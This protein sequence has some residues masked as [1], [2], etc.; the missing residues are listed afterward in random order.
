MFPF[1]HRNKTQ[2]TTALIHDCLH[3]CSRSFAKHL[4][5][6]VQFGSWNLFDNQ[7]DLRWGRSFVVNLIWQWWLRRT[8]RASEEHAIPFWSGELSHGF[9][10]VFSLYSSHC[11]VI[12]CTS[13]RS[14]SKIKMKYLHATRFL[15]FKI[16]YSN[17]VN[18]LERVSKT[19][20][21]DR[22]YS[23]KHGPIIKTITLAHS[24]TP[25]LQY[26][27]FIACKLQHSLVSTAHKYVVWEPY[28]FIV[29]YEN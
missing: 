11:K 12:R 2:S 24:Q 21:A 25:T 13:E 8:Y 18:S 17:S 6:I 9:F 7:G 27:W 4:F 3:D 20:H 14:N 16:R 1:C 26:P 23:A 15:W 29:L 19:F 10:S 5:V 28:K 22:C